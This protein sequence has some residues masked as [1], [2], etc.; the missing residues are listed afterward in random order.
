MSDEIKLTT[1]LRV[2]NGDAKLSWQPGTLSVDQS[3]P[4]YY[5]Q[6][7]TVDNI[8]TTLDPV[9]TGYGLVVVRNLS[10]TDDVALWSDWSASGGSQVP[11]AEL[12]P[13]EY[14]ILRLHSLVQLIAYCYSN[15]AL[16][17]A[18]ILED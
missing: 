18:I 3:N 12:R 7:L 11:F 4:G 9:L 14:A 17:E 13:G 15:D 2:N 16:I 5:W 10:E 6:T 1:S 8:G